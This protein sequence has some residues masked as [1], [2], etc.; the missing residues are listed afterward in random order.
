MYG[1]EYH[2]FGGLYQIEVSG[3]TVVL[4]ALDSLENPCISSFL[5]LLW[6]SG[7]FSLP[8]T[9]YFSTFL[10]H[11]FCLLIILHSNQYQLP[12]RLQLVHDYIMKS[13]FSWPI[14]GHYLKL[15]ICHQFPNQSIRFPH[16]IPSPAI[17]LCLMESA[18]GSIHQSETY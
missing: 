8:N 4:P 11:P 12:L 7:F 14:R 16:L 5:L 18:K 9:G 1:M 15:K 10:Y 17:F 2:F 6:F 3:E 13:L